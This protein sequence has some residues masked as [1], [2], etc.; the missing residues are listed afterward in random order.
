M[1]PHIAKRLKSTTIHKNWTAE[2]FEGVIWNDEYSVEKSK[3]PR[4]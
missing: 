2:D 1:A 3:D 4:Q